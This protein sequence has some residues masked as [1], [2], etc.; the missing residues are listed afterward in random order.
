[1]GKG[2]G[3]GSDIRLLSPVF[4]QGATVADLIRFGA[5]VGQTKSRAATAPPRT[6]YPIWLA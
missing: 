1:M 4:C 2:R 5:L 3:K 6:V